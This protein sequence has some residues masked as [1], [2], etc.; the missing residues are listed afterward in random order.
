MTERARS[1]R[2]ACV[3]RNTL[4]TQIQVELNLDGSGRGEFAT[5]VPFL[6]HMMD[7][8][9]RHGMSPAQYQQE[10][11]TQS[12]NGYRIKQVEGFG[13]GNA[14]HFVAVWEKTTGPA[15]I[16]RHNLTGAQSHQG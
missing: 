8:I 1:E 5:G 13:V 15:L 2:I 16:S 6:E 10:Y 7:Q 12:Q 4:E 9:A 14:I 11:T 3:N